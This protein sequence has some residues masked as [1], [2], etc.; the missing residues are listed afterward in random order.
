MTGSALP[1]R[2]AR[3]TR[4]TR[5]AAAARINW[6][7]PVVPVCT[8]VLLR[9]NLSSPETGRTGRAHFASRQWRASLAAGIALLV[10]SG[11]YSGVL[12]Q[13]GPDAEQEVI[14]VLDQ[15]HAAAA[16]SDFETYFGL[17][18]A[19]AIFMGTDQS[20][21]WTIDEFKGYA[22]PRFAAGKGWSYVSTGRNVYISSNGQS[23]WFD[24]SLEN[25]NLGNC[26][27]SGVLV[28]VEDRWKII[29]YNLSVPIPNAMVRGVVETI[30]AADQ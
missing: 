24:E 1:H 14:R 7:N 25:E 15:L 10:Q 6:R 30:R 5:R 18:A 4:Y 29:Q 21:R 9:S 2:A 8:F 16:S 23:A 17:Y 28:K 12:A 19:D 13:A 22:Q 11:L 27:G 20:E 26:R 3:G